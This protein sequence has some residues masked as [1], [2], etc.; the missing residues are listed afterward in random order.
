MKEV[1]SQLHPRPQQVLL[2][3]YL[4]RTDE[5]IGELLVIK[6]KTVQA[7]KA[8][9]RETCC[10]VGDNSSTITVVRW[11]VESGT[12]DVLKE[13]YRHKAGYAE[14]IA[15]AEKAEKVRLK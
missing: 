7:H 12:I 2:L 5:Q 3:T 4:G 13:E 10:P 9:L 14:L 1:L 8:I 15:K 11:A 6:E